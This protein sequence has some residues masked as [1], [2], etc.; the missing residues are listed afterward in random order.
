MHGHGN[1]CGIPNTSTNNE[2]SYNFPA[3]FL[4]DFMLLDDGLQPPSATLPPL[5]LPPSS[6]VIAAYNDLDPI[7]A[8][9]SKLGSTTSSSSGGYESSISYPCCDDN[10]IPCP[11]AM[12]RSA[13]SHSL[14][15]KKVDESSRKLLSSPAA[16]FLDLEGCFT[17]RVSNA[18]D[19]LV[20]HLPSFF[21]TTI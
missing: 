14:M 11:S 16:E 21:N 9:I 18:G 19:L 6:L 1:H 17:R 20:L 8:L 7:Q 10:R 15:L 5:Y 13:S 2:L 4:P 12:Q 3:D